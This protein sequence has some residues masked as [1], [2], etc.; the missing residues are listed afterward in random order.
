VKF[1]ARVQEMADTD[2]LS[3][4]P[5]S[6]YARIK[7]EDKNPLFRAYAIG[8][9]GIS[10]GRVVGEG[11][12]I[13]RWFASAI[14]KLHD[15]L[16]FGLKVFHNHG[17]TNEHKGR[18]PIGEI[19]GKALQNIG[20]RLTAIAIAYIK[21]KFRHLPLDV[22]SIEAE[23]RLKES[24]GIYDADVSEITGIALG[25]SAINTPGFAGATLMAQIQAFAE[26]KGSRS[27][28]GQEMGFEFGLD[29]V[30]QYV[31]EKRVRPSDIFDLGTLTE[32]PQVLA[33]GKDYTAERVAG[34]FRGRKKA[35]EDL[36]KAKTEAA[37]KLKVVEAKL[38]EKDTIY[39]KILVPGAFEKL[40]GERKLTAKQKAFIKSDLEKFST[41][42]VDAVEA[43]LG[44]H[45]DGKLAD[46]KKITDL[47]G[48]KDEG[49][50]GDKDKGGDKTK[51]PGGE[52]D[53]THA[54]D[55]AEVED[56]YL[57]PTQNPLLRRP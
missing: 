27:Q 36:E 53:D 1:L 56:K 55:K 11:N 49:N 32:D 7:K 38:K 16:F 33:W 12:I 22:A 10:E 50:G 39:V 14:Q 35:E 20:D 2:I 5:A 29:D 18:M 31:K 46:L 19:V 37:E 25:N 51:T 30:R 54:A 41:E 23:I 28:G 8:H 24:G 6:E 26:R 13:K 48:L 9:E 4:I 52:P 42:K 34:E 21:P 17:P 47:L 40:A 3:L 57:D 43:E 44:K 45:I 15:K